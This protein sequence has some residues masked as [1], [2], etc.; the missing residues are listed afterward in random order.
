MARLAIM[1]AVRVT[2]SAAIEQFLLHKTGSFSVMT[3]PCLL[4]LLQWVVMV[5]VTGHFETLLIVQKLIPHCTLQW[6]MLPKSVLFC[7]GIIIREKCMH[8]QIYCI[9]C[10]NLSVSIKIT[11]LIDGIIVWKEGVHKY[12]YRVICINSFITVS[13]SGNILFVSAIYTL[14]TRRTKIVF[15]TIEDIITKCTN[16]PMP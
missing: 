14:I 16:T 7:Y 8:E 13:I 6:G 11:R 15:H 2:V 1:D 3:V 4:V 9:V 10:V 5:T 12:V